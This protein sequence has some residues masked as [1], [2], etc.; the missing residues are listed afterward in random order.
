[1]AVASCARQERRFPLREP[2]WR[3]GDLR[4]VI[5]P[6]HM[7]PTAKDPRHVSCAPRT[8]VSPQ[9]W[10]ET[11]NVLFR[12]LSQTLGI[13]VSDESVD[14]NSLDEVPDSSWFTNRLGVRPMSRDELVLGGCD[15]SS[16]IDPDGA[17]DGSWVIEKGKTSGNSPGFRV[18]VPGKGRYLFKLDDADQPELSSAATV[19]ASAAYHAAGY[20]TTCEQVVYFKPSTLKLT[21]GLRYKFSTLGDEHDFDREA[22]DRILRAAPRRGE[23]VRM[24][25]SAWLPGKLLGPF[26]YE[27]MRADDP[28][29][30]VPHEDRRELRADRLLAAWLGHVDS[31][32]KNSMDIWLAN[33]PSDPDSSPGRVVHSYLDWGDC[34]GG[35]WPQ[36]AITRRMGYSYIVDWGDI[37][38][39][40]LTLGVPLRPWDRN[41]VA[42]YE[43]FGYFDADHFVPDQWKNEYPNPAFIRM[44]E[45]DAAWMARILARFTPEMVLALAEVGQFTDPR[46]TAYV[47]RVLEERLERILERY[48]TRL[49]PI[50]SVQIEKGDR[51]CGVDLA[52]SRRFAKIRGLRYVV[53]ADGG[54]S[55]PV[56]RDEGARL[57]V[58]L[59]HVARD[60]GEPD[61]APSRY[62]RVALEDGLS[63]APLRVHLYDLGPTRGYRIAGIERKER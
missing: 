58:E 57:C 27:G 7:E 30:V 61:D 48:L 34:L 24:L 6:C 63:E 4:S 41:R 35:N 52:A 8:Y 37:A 56:T 5:A 60:G 32:E 16:L 12:R 43:I 14:V 31:N 47:A 49:S 59:N 10:D 50:A 40:F 26:R 22:L 13:A 20:N 15:P 23:R 38:S 44:T 46:H 36:E 39:D 21:R 55:L 19:I 33:R 62:V 3:D 17:T 53:R 2:L 25:A 51:L 42:G 54:V 45:R 29:D 11:D 28:N 9:L 1:M 18:N